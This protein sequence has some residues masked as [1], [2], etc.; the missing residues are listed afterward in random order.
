M[1]IPKRRYGEIRALLV[2]MGMPKGAMTRL[3]WVGDTLW[4]VGRRKATVFLQRD[5]QRLGITLM[6][7]GTAATRT[8]LAIRFRGAGA[9]P[10]RPAFAQEALRALSTPEAVSRAML[11]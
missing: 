7:A 11:Q 1:K 10:A 9:D 8:E 3:E 6:G 2:D 4:I 5:A